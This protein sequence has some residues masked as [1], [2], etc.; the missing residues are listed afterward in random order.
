MS[1]GKYIT[2]PYLDTALAD[3]SSD[4]L[5][6]TGG[7]LT[8][9]LVINKVVSDAPALDFSSTPAAGKPA[10]KFQTVSADSVTYSTFGTSDKFYEYAWNFEDKEDFCWVYADNNKVFSITKDGPAC[11]Q[12]YLADFGVNDLNGRVLHN[13]IDVRDRLTKYQETFK[14]IRQAVGSSTDYDSLKENLLTA[15][16]NV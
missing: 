11:S 5:T 3:L 16:V 13:K 4:Y 15:L 8:G 7:T 6:H 1:S 9:S 10:F 12:L 2:E 14:A